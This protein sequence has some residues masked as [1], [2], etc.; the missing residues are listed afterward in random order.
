MNFFEKVFRKLFPTFYKQQ[1]ENTKLL[2]A[3]KKQNEGLTKSLNKLL[4][5][6]PV[7][8]RNIRISE[9]AIM[10]QINE[11]I[12]DELGKLSALNEKEIDICGAMPDDETKK[13]W[14][15]LHF[16]IALKKEFEKRGY[17]ANIL[18]YEQWQ[19]HSS[20]KFTLVLRGVKPFFPRPLP[21]KKFIMWNIS[22]PDD[23]SIEEYNL[24]D[25]VFFASEKLRQKYIDRIIPSAGLLLQCTDPDVMCARNL[26]RK[27]YDLLFV[28]NSRGVFRSILKDLLPTAY[29]LTVYGDGWDGFPVQPYVKANYLDNELVGQAY[30]DAKILLNDH[31][32]DMRK[33]GI[34]SNRIFDALAVGAFV[35]SD[36]LP[37]IDELFDGA[38]VMYHGKEDL[39]QKIEYYLSHEELRNQLAERGKQIVLPHHTFRDRVNRL[40]E[41][42]EAM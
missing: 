2:Q 1:Q 20:A 9:S 38:V 17:K 15:D 19:V 14:G 29:D 23:I 26:D 13:S 11:R 27:E 25:Y 24:Y 22:H 32:D 30:H 31:W 4:E 21:G 5:F 10:R 12:T 8:E 41:V 35:I 18:N 7:M 34:V 36:Y 37:E 33:T 3:L 6:T 40:L 16:A 39:A 28:G 42:M